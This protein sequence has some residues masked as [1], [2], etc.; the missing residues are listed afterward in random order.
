MQIKKQVAINSTLLAKILI[1][2]LNFISQFI[3]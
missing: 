1:K 2:A 3:S